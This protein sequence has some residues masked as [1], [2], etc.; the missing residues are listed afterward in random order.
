M[1]NW[2]VFPFLMLTARA[3]DP[4]EQWDRKPAEDWRHAF[5]L[6]GGPWGARV[7]GGTSLERIMMFRSGPG[8][9]SVSPQ[10]DCLILNWLNHEQVNGYRRSLDRAKG[11][12]TTSFQRNGARITETVFLSKIDSLLVVHLLADKPGALNFRV[13]LLSN[14][15]RIKDR[16][17]LDSKGLRV[18][19]LPFESDVEADG[20]GLVVRGEGEALILLSTGTRR[21]L[22]GRLRDLGMKYDGRDSFP[23]LTRIWAGLKKSKENESMGN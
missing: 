23:D 19:V 6:R 3:A 18:W 16:R 8:F 21:E 12:A 17:E 22:D 7:F 9:D 4:F 14:A 5:A 10:V 13:C 2:L 11:I 20:E 15:Y 1:L